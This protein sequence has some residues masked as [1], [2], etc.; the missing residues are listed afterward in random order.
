MEKM[1]S[2]KEKKELFDNLKAPKKQKKP[3][4]TQKE[5][6]QPGFCPECGAYVGAFYKC[7]WCQS[8]MPHGTR[9][10]VFQI[11]SIL[12]LIVGLFVLGSVA[13]INPAPKVNIG[14]I[15]PTYSNGIVTIEG[16]INDINYY[17]GSNAT[18]KMLLF[19]VEDDTG[20]IDVKCYTEM[21]DELIDEENTPAIGDECE[22]RGSVFVR[23]EE[24]YMLLESSA[25]LK[26][27]RDVDLTINATDLYPIYEDHLGERVKVQ[28]TVDYV[29][30]DGTFFYIDTDDARDVRV[31]I[32]EYIQIFYPET[33]INV[34]TGDIIEVTGILEEYVDG[35]PQIA[36]G[37]AKDIDIIGSGGVLD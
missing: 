6:S 36:P 20:S 16:N 7:Q 1:E 34:L 15:G 5:K 25:H 4:G 18:W 37:S 33:Q 22:V 10:R 13:R 26:I 12:A 35:V 21:V 19:T 29:D 27:S 23:G 14:D 32:P 3:V 9:L 17:E 24:L 8:K 2:E 31:Y 11:S 30:E 28:G